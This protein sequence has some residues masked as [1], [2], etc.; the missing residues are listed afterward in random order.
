MPESLNAA[1]NSAHASC[2]VKFNKKVVRQELERVG[3]FTN[4]RRRGCGSRSPSGSAPALPVPITL[5]SS[6]LIDR[7]R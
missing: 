2:V 3:L 7:L 6:S 1:E 5:S 4:A